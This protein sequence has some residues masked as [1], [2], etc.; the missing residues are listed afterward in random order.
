MIST[1]RDCRNWRKLLLSHVDLRRVRDKSD[2]RVVHLFITSKGEN[3][4]KPGT[5]AGWNF[6]E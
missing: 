4:L 5:L 3:A 2:R 1:M 6:V